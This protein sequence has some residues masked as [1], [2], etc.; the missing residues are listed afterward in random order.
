M[1]ILIF[2]TLAIAYIRGF[3]FAYLYQI[4]EYRFDRLVS[5]INEDGFIK[6]F[7]ISPVRRPAL[8]IRNILILCLHTG[9]MIFLFLL[10][11]E[12][13]F[14]YM[15]LIA[16]III[17]P[18]LGFLTVT[19]A[20]L[21][22]EIPVRIYRHFLIL[23]A[24]IKVRSEKTIFVGIAGSFGKT[25][26]KEYVAHLLSARYNVAKTE[27]NMNTD[28]GIAIAINKNLTA[29]T[30]YFITEVGSY[31]AGETR[32]AT[33]YIPFT[34]G[35]LTGLG[36]QHVD[37]Y[38]SRET[39][40]LEE[41]SLLYRIPP[42]G[43]AYINHSVPNRATLQKEIKAKIKTFDFSHADIKA[44]IKNITT[45]KTIAQIQY[46]GYDFTIETQLP[47]QHS[48]LNL[49]PAIALAM[50]CGLKPREIVQ[51]IATLKTVEGK[52]SRHHGKSKAIILNDAVNSNVDGFLAALSVLAHY[53]Q[54]TKYVVSPGIIELGVEKRQSYLKILEK[55]YTINAKLLTTDS[56]FKELDSKNEVMI[57]ND[58]LQL[59]DKIIHLMNKHTVLLLEG[60]LP[61]NIKSDILQVK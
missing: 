32:R 2:I 9:E 46:N 13:Q 20:V 11:L 58:V 22:T 15:A 31:R 40:I 7:Y 52:L 26:V 14:L 33:W 44:K 4:K 37:L 28:V 12:H 42:S 57:F 25:S 59:R 29:N 19:I 18:T 55:L 56:L 41:S 23:Q 8:S 51:Q 60:K 49:L 10:A 61:E 21:I 5:K 45:D 3:F 35:I 50:D 1:I 16:F 6:T 34:Y 36:N 43:T 39:L 27:K 38:G 47:G 53:P 30:E 17:A 54:K 48:L 24:V